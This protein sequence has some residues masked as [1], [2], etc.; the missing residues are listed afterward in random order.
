MI[1][2]VDEGGVS[3]SGEMADGQPMDERDEIS[4]GVSD[5]WATSDGSDDTMVP[6]GG[7]SSGGEPS[8]GGF[9][10][11]DTMAGAAGPSGGSTHDVMGDVGVYI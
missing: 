3:A 1:G 7:Q 4:M 2:G 5:R 10:D 6:R 8:R 11:T 9:G